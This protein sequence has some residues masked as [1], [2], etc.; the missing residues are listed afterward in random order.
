MTNSQPN[1]ISFIEKLAFRKT[2]LNKRRLHNH[3]K[4]MCFL[5]NKE[6]AQC[7]I[8]D[9]LDK[10]ENTNVNGGNWVYKPKRPIY[11]VLCICL[12]S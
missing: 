1:V 3:I 11:I 10:K 5:T 12:G 6:N 9:T 2:F 4:W 7:D 8:D